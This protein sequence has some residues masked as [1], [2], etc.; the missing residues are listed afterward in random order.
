MKIHR[1]TD[2][3]QRQ[4]EKQTDLKGKRQRAIQGQGKRQRR[5]KWKLTVRNKTETERRAKTAEGSHNHYFHPV[6]TCG[7]P[8][9]R[10]VCLVKIVVISVCAV[11]V[12]TSTFL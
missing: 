1:E 4:S 10:L 11:K 2:G 6:R 9:Q 3:T 7:T 8:R 5:K 12:V